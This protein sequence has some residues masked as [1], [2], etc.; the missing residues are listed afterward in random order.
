M[1]PAFPMDG[2]RVLRA[3]LAITHGLT[4]ARPRSRRSI[5]QGVAFALGF[6]G[7][8]AQ[9]DADL[10]RDLRLSRGILGSAP[11]R[12]PRDVARRADE[13]RDDD[14]IRHAR[15]RGARGGGGADAAAHQP[16]RVP[17]GRRDGQA[18]RPARTRRPHPRAQ[19]ARPRR[20]R[21]R[22]DDDD[23]PDHR[24]PRLPRRGVP[25]VAGE[26]G[27]GRRRRRCERPPR[28]PRHLRDRRRDADAARGLAR[29]RAIWAVDAA[30]RRADSCPA[31]DPVVSDSAG[32]PYPP[33]R[34]LSH[35]ASEFAGIFALLSSTRDVR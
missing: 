14:A 33:S 28:R 35:S 26:I 20:P 23:V 11:G 17:S 25:H 30:D 1:I 18:G 15:A 27:A 22:R 32:P 10:H 5:G 6:I 12:D 34:I 9:P 8:F 24:P 16:E 7:L 19:A 4:C 13:R 29:G 31:L 3:L 2:G 21:R